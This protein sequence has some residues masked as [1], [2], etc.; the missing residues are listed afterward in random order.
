V[1]ADLD[2][3]LIA[4]YVELTGHII[5]SLGLTRS[6]PGQRLKVTDAELACIVVAQVLLR[7][8]DERHWPADRTER[9]GGRVP[10]GLWARDH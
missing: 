5:P 4:L 7:F 9:H 3:F 10:A 8:D 1:T 6:G 2:T